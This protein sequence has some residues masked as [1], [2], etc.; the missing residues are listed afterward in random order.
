[1]EN[2]H[3]HLVR[4]LHDLRNRGVRVR[5]ITDET[6]IGGKRGIY[7][8]QLTQ[9]IG[10]A[11]LRVPEIIQLNR[12]NTKK[13]VRLRESAGYWVEG[14][15]RIPKDAQGHQWLIEE[16]LS[17]GYSPYDDVSDA[18]SDVWTDGIW[19]RPQHG[20]D[21][22]PTMPR[23]PGDEVLKQQWEDEMEAIKRDLFRDSFDTH[24]DDPQP[25]ESFL[26]EPTNERLF[27]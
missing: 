19:R 21:H 7:R 14:Y 8:Q 4:T 13:V 9:V 2:F 25:Y 24:D 11:G 26:V 22:Q 12:G 3:D 18:A 1:M 10:N 5:A 23:Q 15:V 16:M 27:D 17:I 20:N 6:E